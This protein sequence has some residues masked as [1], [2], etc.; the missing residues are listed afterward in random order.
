MKANWRQFLLKTIGQYKTFINRNP[1]LRIQLDKGIKKCGKLDIKLCLVLPDLCFQS[2]QGIFR[3][4]KYFH[5]HNFKHK[6]LYSILKKLYFTFLAQRTLI[7]GNL[8]NNLLKACA[9]KCNIPACHQQNSITT[10]TLVLID[11]FVSMFFIR[12]V[13]AFK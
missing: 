1:I 13:A 4:L 2:C 11:D 8:I 9:F 3:Y 10:K 6:R 12:M 5:P 7:L